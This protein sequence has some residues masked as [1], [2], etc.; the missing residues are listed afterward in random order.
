MRKSIHSSLFILCIIL[1]FTGAPKLKGQDFSKGDVLHLTVERGVEIGLQNSKSLHASSMKVEY[2]DAKESEMRTNRLPSLKFSGGYTKL[3][4]IPDAQLTLPP[5]FNLP[6]VTISQ[7]ILNNYS[8]KLTLQQPLFTGYRV[9]SGIQSAEYST[10]AAEQDY[11]EDKSDLIYNIKNAYWGL[12]KAG[13][14]KKVIDEN[15]D[16]VKAHLADVQNLLDHGMA[17]NNEKLRVEVQLSNAKLAQIDANNNVRL[18]MIALDNVMG[19][20]LSKQVEIASLPK[21]QVDSTGK[22]VS[23][24]LNLD[25]LIIRAK[26]QR[27][28][29]KAMGY[30]V[31]AGEAGVTAS[32]SG[33]FPQ[34]FLVGDYNYARPNTRIFPTLDQFKDTWDVGVVASWDLWN[35]GATIQQTS[36][37]QSQLAQAQD[38]YGQLQDGVTLEVTQNYLNVNQSSERIGVSLQAVNQAQENYRVVNEKYKSGLALNTDLLDAEVSL[39]QAKT[40]YTQSLVDYE[41]A[42]AR[43]SKAVGE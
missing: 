9:E 38:A 20:P 22:G 19:V 40:N 26:D 12:F 10:R 31:K 27:P 32:K 16:Q 18:A 15:V 11:S 5:Q 30:R 1:D 42:L 21:E 4:S 28:E 39:L 17:T 13:E 6:P 7:T 14:F 23:A 43:L 36:Q 33:W 2:A 37:A 8:S 24:P 34:I 29:I 3:S 25:G 41:L 35:W